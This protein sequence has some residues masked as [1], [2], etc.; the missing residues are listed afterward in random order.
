MNYYV[1]MEGH[2]FADKMVLDENGKPKNQYTDKDGNVTI[3]DYDLVPILDKFVEEHPDFAYHGHKA[4][5][6]FTGYN[7]VLGYRTDETFDPNSPALDPKNRA[8]PILKKIRKP[9]RRLPGP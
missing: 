1:Y 8:T 9:L 2:G 5:I 7:G 4:V 6:A 3:G